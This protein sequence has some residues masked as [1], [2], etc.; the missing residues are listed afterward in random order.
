MDRRNRYLEAALELFITHGFH[1][2]SMDQLVAATGGSKATLYRYF[3]SKEAL[4]EAII[5]DVASNTV[6]TPAGVHDEE[7]S[8]VDLMDGLRLIGRA[9]AAGA[10]AERTIVLLRLALGEHQRFPQLGHTLFT[11]GPAVSYARLRHFL[12]AKCADG[13]AAIDDVQIAAEQFLGGIV[14]H[15]QL[16][17]ALGVDHATPEEMAARVEAA[18]RSFIAVYGTR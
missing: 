10:M 16:R 15:Q 3:P 6:G 11:H 4:F 7:W 18:V 17:L 8:D 14:G 5:D 9:V 12:A 1:G 2:M 13:V